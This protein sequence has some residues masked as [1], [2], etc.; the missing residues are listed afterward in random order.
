MQTDNKLSAFW[1]FDTHNDDE[2]LLRNTVDDCCIS[3]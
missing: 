3:Y 1:A 2:A